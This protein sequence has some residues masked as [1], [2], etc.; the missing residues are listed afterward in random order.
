LHQLSVTGPKADVGRAGYN[1]SHRMR[2]RYSL[3]ALLAI[4]A[5]SSIPVSAQA[6]TKAAWQD[7]RAH[8]GSTLSGHYTIPE[9]NTALRTMPAYVEEYS[10]CY[11]VIQAQLLKQQLKVKPAPKAHASSDKSSGSG[12]TVLIAAI[13]AVATGGLGLALWAN[14]RRRRGS[15]P[16]DGPPTA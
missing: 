13:A 10:N 12:S 5:F 9:L 16:A 14:R 1:L 4:A 7:C 8:G 2:R 3:A 11:G 6:A 15:P